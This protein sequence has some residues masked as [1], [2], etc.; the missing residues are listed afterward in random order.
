MVMAKSKHAA[1]DGSYQAL[2]AELSKLRDDVVSLGGTLR[3]ITSDEVHAAVD[4]IRDR[5]DKA[6]VEAHKAARRAKA[7]VH[8]A[9]DAIEGAIEEH[10]FTSIL[11]ALGLGFL[12]GAFMRR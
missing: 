6:A 8:D 5:L 11:I 7:G 3:D 10:P 9:A 2:E 12:I 1:G 4:A